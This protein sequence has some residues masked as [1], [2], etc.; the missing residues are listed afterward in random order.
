MLKL[1]NFHDF[2]AKIRLK[3][4]QNLMEISNFHDFFAKIRCFRRTI[5]KG[6]C[7]LFTRTFERKRENKAWK[8]PIFMTFL[9][10]YASGGLE[11]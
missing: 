7:W 11:I 3:I 4:K 9:P 8:F 5:F 10:K 1:S 6:K 2:F